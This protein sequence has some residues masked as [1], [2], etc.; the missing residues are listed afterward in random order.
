MHIAVDLDGT[1]IPECAEFDCEP[2]EGIARWIYLYSLRTGAK[3]LLRELIR[4]GQRVSIYTLSNRSAGKLKLWFFLHG[5]RVHRVINQQAHLQQVR[6]GNA[7]HKAIKWPPAFGIDLL[8]D[9]NEQNIQAA[10]ASG[11]EAILVH[12]HPSDWTA[13]IRLRCPSRVKAKKLA[14]AVVEIGS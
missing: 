8:I 7:V 9:D 1:L 13:A 11:A 6:K 5:I 4:S 2:T 14:R 3:E 12:S 10:Y